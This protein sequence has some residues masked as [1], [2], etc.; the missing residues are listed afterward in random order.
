MKNFLLIIILLWPINAWG[1][2]TTLSSGVV[3]DVAPGFVVSG[4][5][6]MAAAIRVLQQ[7]ENDGL[8]EQLRESGLVNLLAKP[9]GTVRLVAANNADVHIDIIPKDVAEI[10]EHGFSGQATTG[11][12]Y[13]YM[14]ENGQSY[15]QAISNNAQALLAGAGGQPLDWQQ[16][17]W[18]TADKIIMWYQ[19]ALDDAP[20]TY[21]NVA[22]VYQAFFIFSE[23]NGLEVSSQYP[24]KQQAGYEPLLRQMVESLEIPEYFMLDPE[25][26]RIVLPNSIS[27]TVPPGWAITSYTQSSE[28]VAYFDKLG[29][30][31]SNYSQM[32]LFRNNAIYAVVYISKH[33]M[34]RYAAGVGLNQYA[35]DF[36]NNPAKFAQFY[37][38]HFINYFNE[39]WQ[40]LGWSSCDIAR[41]KLSIRNLRN[42]QFLYIEYTLTSAEQ[43]QT[44]TQKHLFFTPAYTLL[45]DAQY[46]HVSSAL[47]QIP[48][49]QIVNSIIL[50]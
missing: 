29:D 1:E 48:I 33:I 14:L 36:K 17:I 5:D 7:P 46:N 31:A 30:N 50:P 8:Y 21:A 26:Y 41:N 15:L 9:R 20:G 2:L 22:N 49:T 18:R 28:L 27:V 25:Q 38:N 47:V 34:D 24:L 3:L 23:N 6:E 11:G 39:N 12:V 40:N 13:Q 44:I 16:G 45:V 32:I 4:D 37:N 10:I 43:K 19:Y 35:V 42:Q